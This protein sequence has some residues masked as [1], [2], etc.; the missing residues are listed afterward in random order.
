MW[1]A[2]T[3]PGTAA[4]DQGHQQR[5][6]GGGRGKEEIAMMLQP[7][8]LLCHTHTQRHTHT[9]TH[10]D[11]HTNRHTQTHTETHSQTHTYKDTHTHT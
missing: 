8:R 3:V 11:T 5:G 6:R 10:R 4:S 9:E 7:R 1:E 2:Q